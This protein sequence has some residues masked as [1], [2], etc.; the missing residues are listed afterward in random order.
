MGKIKF[1]LVLITG[2]L[3]LLDYHVCDYFYPKDLKAWWHLRHT[4]YAFE[5]LLFCFI[6][7]IGSKGYIRFTL[8][9]LMALI[10]GDIWDRTITGTTKFINSDYILIFM[11]II[12]TI[13]YVKKNKN[14]RKI[15]NTSRNN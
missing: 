1:A 6:A 10:L 7:T 9:I 11:I 5:F 15:Q 2:I 4:L 14:A 12:I 3:F 13:L 8:T